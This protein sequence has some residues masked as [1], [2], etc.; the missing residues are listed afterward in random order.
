MP[1]MDFNSNAPIWHTKKGWNH[2]KRI[3]QMWR[4]I[5]P[6]V[7]T[8]RNYM[9]KDTRPQRSRFHNLNHKANRRLQEIYPWRPTKSSKRQKWQWNMGSPTHFRLP[10]L[11]KKSLIPSHLL[12][13]SVRPRHEDET[14]K[15]KY[16]LSSSHLLSRSVRPRDGKEV[17][18]VHTIATSTHQWP[19][20]RTSKSLPPRNSS[21]LLPT[22]SQERKGAPMKKR[23][24]M[25]FE[26]H[27]QTVER[28]EEEEPFAREKSKPRLPTKK[29]LNSKNTPQHAPLRR[30]RGKE[31]QKEER[32][33]PRSW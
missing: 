18:K 16:S 17:Q 23:L 7:E 25:K 15:V 24:T 13:W 26:N 19:K 12:M 5:W 27:N 8:T 22:Y 32:A 11:L 1:S 14:Q 2:D 10:W 9:A 30:S 3:N 29:G 28:E 31:V 4:E 21:K 33:Q 20:R 6:L